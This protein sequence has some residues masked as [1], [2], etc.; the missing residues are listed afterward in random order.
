MNIG[1]YYKIICGILRIFFYTL[2]VGNGTKLLN[3]YKEKTIV[4]RNVKFNKIC[5]I[6]SVYVW[7]G[8]IIKNYLKWLIT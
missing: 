5:M 1:S 2:N 7:I 3:K 6:T 8:T 4:F